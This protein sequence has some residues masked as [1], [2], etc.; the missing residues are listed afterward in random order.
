MTAVPTYAFVHGAWHA[1]W[2]WHLAAAEL[3]RRGYRTVAV[4]LPCADPAAGAAAYAECVLRALSD[5]D[6]EVVLVGHSLG[7][8]TIPVV[9]THRPVRAMV[10]LAAMI[11]VVGASVDEVTAADGIAGDVPRMALPGLGRGQIGHDD[12]ATSWRP[13]VAVEVL[14][15]DAP[16]ALG[17]EA[18]ARLRRQCWRPVQE[19]TPLTIWPD[20]PSAYVLCTDDAVMNPAWSRV[21]APARLGVTPIEMPGDHSPFLARPVAL[22]DVLLAAAASVS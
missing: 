8:L 16:A 15:P 20:S 19:I 4:D 21:A 10:F 14:Y 7:G 22:V 2:H 6:D 3:E 17:A 11:P 5:V 12:G 18:A 1:G 13:E 9:A